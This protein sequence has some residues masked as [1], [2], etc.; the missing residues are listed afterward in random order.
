MKAK[1]V[2]CTLVLMFSA[3]AGSVFGGTEGLYSTFYGLNAGNGNTVSD[4]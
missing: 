4:S 3:F 2:I 1:I